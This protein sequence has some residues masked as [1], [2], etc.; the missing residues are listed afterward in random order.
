MKSLLLSA[1]AILALAAPVLADPNGIAE[2]IFAQSHETGDG[3]KRVVLTSRG[4]VDAA[5]AH[6]N[7]DHETG[8]GARIRTATPIDVIISTSNSALAEFARMK[9]DSDGRGSN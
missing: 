2:Q 3:P 4:D 6:F 1:A 7:Q 9:L 8:D 5:I